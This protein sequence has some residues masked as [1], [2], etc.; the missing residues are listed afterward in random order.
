MEI[1]FYE[2]DLNF[3]IK[4]HLRSSVKFRKID[5]VVYASKF[6]GARERT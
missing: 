5:A 3:A 1:K 4:F 2:H 6:T